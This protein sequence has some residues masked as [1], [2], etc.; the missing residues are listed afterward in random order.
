VRIVTKLSV[1]AIAGFVLAKRFAIATSLFGSARR[2]K[3]RV[4][5]DAPAGD[6]VARREKVAAALGGAHGAMPERRR[7]DKGD[8]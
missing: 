8:A 3:R 4:I 5:V 1:N 7:A 2:K 6:Q